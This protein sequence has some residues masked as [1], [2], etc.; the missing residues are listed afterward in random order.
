MVLARKLDGA[1]PTAVTRSRLQLGFASPRTFFD[2]IDHY[3]LNIETVGVLRS[4]KTTKDLVH[5]TN[6]LLGDFPPN[7]WLTRGDPDNSQ[8]GG[9]DGPQRYSEAEDVEDASIVCAP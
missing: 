5:A 7:A 4:R 2:P 1:Q 8:W 9:D 6:H 3:L